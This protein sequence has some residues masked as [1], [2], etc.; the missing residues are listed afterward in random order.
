M[1]YYFLPIIFIFLSSTIS[2][3]NQ[4]DLSLSI[5]FNSL[6]LEV[7]N[8]SR[9][10]Y[11]SPFKRG[12]TTIF[13]ISTESGYIFKNKYWKLLPANSLVKSIKSLPSNRGNAPLALSLTPQDLSHYM[14]LDKESQNPLNFHHLFVRALI[15]SPGEK[16]GSFISTS[17]YELIIKDNRISEIKEISNESIP[18][19]VKQ[20]FDKEIEKI[21]TEE[22][23][24]EYGY[25]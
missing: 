7:V 9:F 16:A 24:T 3:A 6:S 13:L 10:D 8:N 1:N 23:S 25:W 17:I 11:I 22:N 5:C 21:A 14:P 18:I 2:F 4:I 20:A 15:K 19:K 12:G